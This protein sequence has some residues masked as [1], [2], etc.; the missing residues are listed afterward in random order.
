MNFFGDTR[1]RA[2]QA[3]REVEELLQQAEI[4]TP[5]VADRKRRSTGQ[6]DE[7][8]REPKVLKAAP[9]GSTRQLP[10]VPVTV[11]YALDGRM[12]LE[13]EALRNIRPMLENIFHFVHLCQHPQRWVSGWPLSHWELWFVEEV[14]QHRR[15][16]L[17]TGADQ[18]QPIPEDALPV[19]AL[20]PSTRAAPCVAPAPLAPTL[21]PTTWAASISR[22]GGAGGCSSFMWADGTQAFSP[23]VKHRAAWHYLGSL[24]LDAEGLCSMHGEFSD[25]EECGE[26]WCEEEGWGGA[27]SLSSDLDTEGE[28]LEEE[29]DEEEEG[30]EGEEEQEEEEEDA[31]KE[32][33]EEEEE[34]EVGGGVEVDLRV[35]GGRSVGDPQ[36]RSSAAPSPPAA[37]PVWCV[38]PA[39]TQRQQLWWVGSAPAPATPCGPLAILLIWEGG[40]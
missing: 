13:G 37:G 25:G 12:Y 5:P 20:C 14:L 35:P 4:P 19:P 28:R 9:S 3:K 16:T 36:C 32:Q 34:E 2:T 30:E 39:C 33:E 24:G 11:Q 29:T 26:A 23:Q 38:L 17:T 8:G 10:N 40:S 21:C 18:L 15:E 7:E 31:K 22:G 6:E 1:Q 27:G